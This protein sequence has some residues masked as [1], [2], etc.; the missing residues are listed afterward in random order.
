[1]IRLTPADAAVNGQSDIYMRLANINMKS[2]LFRTFLS[3]CI[4]KLAA[5]EDLGTVEELAE[6]VK[7]KK[8]QTNGT[9]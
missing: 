8:E 5:Y 1:M 9:P 7:A 4:R 6:L 3:D 2:E